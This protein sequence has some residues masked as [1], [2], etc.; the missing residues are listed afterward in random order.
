MKIEKVLP[1]DA[2]ELAAIYAPYVEKTA[3]TFEYEV[4]SETEFKERI[5]QISKQYPYIKVVDDGTIT[6]Y[7]YA[8]CFKNRK[9]YDWSVETTVYIREDCKRKGYGKALYDQLE[10]SLKGMGILTMNACIG[11]P[12]HENPYLTDDSYHFHQRMGFDLVGRFHNSGYKFDQWF[13]MIWMEKKLGE[14]NAD[15]PKVKFG[16]WSL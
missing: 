6:G 11:S 4:P 1:E 7:A 2:K 14:Y 5:V 12:I 13:D 3:I 10:R 9:A 16:E 8:S 15:P